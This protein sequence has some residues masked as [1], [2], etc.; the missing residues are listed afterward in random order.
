MILNER[1]VIERN[2]K[3]SIKRTD[4]MWRIQFR[5]IRV[6]VLPKMVMRSIHITCDLKF[7]AI[8]MWHVWPLIEFLWAPLEPILLALMSNLTSVG[9]HKRMHNYAQSYYN[10]KTKQKCTNLLL[11]FNWFCKILIWN[12]SISIPS[13]QYSILF[14][15]I[16]CPKCKVSSNR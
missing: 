8:L 16:K 6:P 3:A 4:I 5:R 13:T 12:T 11:Q 9:K 10:C 15:W 1:K 7:L 2:Y 14:H